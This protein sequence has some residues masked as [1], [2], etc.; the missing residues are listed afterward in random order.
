[1]LGLAFAAAEPL[2]GGP[3]GYIFVARLLLVLSSLAGVVA[4]YRMGQRVSPTH[5]FLAGLVTTTWFEFVYFAGRPLTEAVATT[6]LLVGLALAS[7]SEREFSR[8]RL[9]SIGFCFALCLLLRVHLILGL[10]VAWIWVGRSHIE[11]WW[12][13]GLGALIPVALFGIADTIVWG[14]PFQSYIEAIE[15]N[16]FKGGAS[17]YGTERFDWYFRL[18]AH[19]WSYAAPIL[20]LLVVMGTR[21]LMLWVLVALCI[22]LAHSII[23]HKEYRFVFPA[24]ACLIVTAAMASAGLIRSLRQQWHWAGAVVAAGIWVAVSAALAFAPTYQFEWFTSRDVIDAEFL[25]A[26]QPNLCGI[27]LYHYPR[28]WET[29]GYAYL[30]RN[31]PFYELHESDRTK[32]S[33]VA[34]VFNAVVLPRSSAVDFPKEFTLRKCFGGKADQT[35]VMMR[36]GSCTPISTSAVSTPLNT[37]FDAEHPMRPICRILGPECP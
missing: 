29:G 3:E 35:C 18:L 13:M 37:V 21:S 9:I 27:L 11:R 10:L 8:K 20:L 15:L 7:V 5:A 6:A 30:H 1:M 16:L 23:P 25:L 22:L 26:K 24:F 32:V 12:L 36:D 33:T 19:Q 4:V 28:W 2:V 31:V 17:H 34:S 14:E